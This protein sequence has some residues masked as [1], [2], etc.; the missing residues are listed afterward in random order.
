[1]QVAHQRHGERPT[2]GEYRVSAS[3]EE[4]GR[5]GGREL[6]VLLCARG[7]LVRSRAR[8]ARSLEQR[9]GS[10]YR[11]GRGCVPQFGNDQS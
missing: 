6:V 1:M 5:D 3:G 9:R 8:R 10:V 11:W 7:H 4:E 2:K